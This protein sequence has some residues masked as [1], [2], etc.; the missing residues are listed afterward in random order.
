MPYARCGAKARSAWL[1]T[2]ASLWRPDFPT[3]KV[4]VKPS[5]GTCISSTPLP[6]DTNTL[7]LQKLSVSAMWQFPSVLRIAL[8]GPVS[9]FWS[10]ASFYISP[11]ALTASLPGPLRS[12]PPP[13]SSLLFSQVLPLASLSLPWLSHSAPHYKKEIF[14]NTPKMHSSP[15][16]PSPA[17]RAGSFGLLWVASVLPTASDSWSHS[18]DWEG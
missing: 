6:P 9:R 1:P 10:C 12:G 17:Q 7:S 8:L 3:C 4:E 15:K 11:C 16:D 13:S 18:H 5:L 14:P 2:P